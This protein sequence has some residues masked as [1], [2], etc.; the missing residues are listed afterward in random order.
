MNV[1]KLHSDV[2]KGLNLTQLGLT[3]CYCRHGGA[4]EDRASGSQ[5]LLEVQKRGGLEEFHR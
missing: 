1:W 3:L 2:L 5:S 4:R